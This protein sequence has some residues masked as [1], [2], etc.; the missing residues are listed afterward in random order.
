MS[1]GPQVAPSNNGL[2][3][4]ANDTVPDSYYNLIDQRIAEHAVA[5]GDALSLED[6][7]ETGWNQV[8]EASVPKGS[9]A[10]DQTA[11]EI[12][13]GDVQAQT[14]SELAQPVASLLRRRG[15]AERTAQTPT[16][17]SGQVVTQATPMPGDYAGFTEQENAEGQR[18]GVLPYDMKLGAKIMTRLT[19][20]NTPAPPADQLYVSS[21]MVAQCPLVFF[22]SNLFIGAPQCNK[23]MGVWED[24]ASHRAV[25]RWHTNS[26]GVNFGVDSALTGNGSVTFA[27]LNAQASLQGMSFGLS[28]C[29]DIPRYTI[30]EQVQ[31]FSSMSNT[32]SSGSPGQSSSSGQAFFYKYII[33]APN[34]STV[35]ESTLYRSNQSSINFT[36]LNNEVSS[37]AMVASATRQGTWTGSQW[38][39]CSGT[40][41]GWNVNFGL[42]PQNI[43]MVA[44]V[45]DLRVAVTAAVTL[46]AYREETMSAISG[47]SATGRTSL[48]K[49]LLLAALLWLLVIVIIILLYLLLRRKRVDQKLKRAL[50]KFQAAL[51]PQRPVTQRP[52]IMYP[53]Y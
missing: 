28:N 14:V 20:R 37:G 51:F 15:H 1:S 5:Q 53:T 26:G 44:T 29:L 23:K 22:G 47:H 50:F 25:V 36:M 21:Q 12:N 45:M 32:V 6:E 30:E 52:V 7:K 2:T 4:Q 39:E 49:N 40:R 24:P 43:D 8:L 3:P 13:D 18:T 11:Q 17:S 33:R 42:A 46:M 41:R 34:G 10:A 16:G 31:E 27:N 9:T 38:R 19:D 35:A 48:I